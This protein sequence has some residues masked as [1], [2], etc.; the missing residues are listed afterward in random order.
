VTR[1]IL[2][3]VLLLSA[4]GSDDAP[5]QAEAPPEAPF[6]FVD[7]AA[8]AGVTAP[9]WCGGETKPHLLESGGTGLA[10]VDYDADGDLDLYLVNGWR[11]DGSRVVERGKNV[12]YRN[13]GDGSF[14]DATAEAGVGDEGW[15]CGVAVGD[16]DGDALPDLYVSNFG[17]DVLYRNRGDGSF[18][19]LA[20]APS[21]DGWSAGA[22]FFDA[23]GDGDEDLFV[24]GYV[25]ATLEE[26]LNAEPTLEWEG[27]MV[28]LGPFGLQGE[29][30]RYFENLGGGR[31]RDATEATGLTDEGLYYSFAVVALDVDADLDL[32]LYIANDSNPNYLYR[33]DGAGHFQETGLWSGAALDAAGNAQGGMG[34]AAG[35][36]DGD[37]DP[38]LVV[39]NF[40]RDASTL[41]ENLGDALFVDISAK[42]GVAEPSFKPLSWGAALADFDL[43]GDL[44]LF[45]ANG[46]IYPQ[47]D[48]VP[49][50][51]VG[52]A[53]ANLLLA[54]EG[55]RFSDTV[56]AAGPG[57]AALGS[58]RGV[59][60]GDI[61]NDGDLDLAV[62]NVDAPPTLLRNDTP[63]RGN[64]LLV[65]APGAR[66]VVIEAGGRRFVREGLVGASYLSA[67]D[68]RF[69]FGLGPATEVDSLR[70]IWPDGSE[71]VRS[72]LAPNQRVSVRR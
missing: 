18:E 30:N 42:A 48:E 24:A 63:H 40:G 2:V 57:L 10:F 59:A 23:D 16:A 36:A 52:Y 11:L 3:P 45:I 39:M 4:C 8:E 70:V 62:A 33:N 55:G 19:E 5:P 72:G 50:V 32:D 64:W 13:R 1:W 22:V 20:G 29:A 35:D 65:D 47:A 37:G 49:E 53:Q 67:S 38:E 9:T 71:T 61:D 21:I 41:Y 60:V 56:G 54:N 27:R 14:E 6:H 46:H 66:R 44:D 15:G 31:F 28:M 26:V 25:E 68:P 58:S 7:V 17:P 51:A 34:L 69:H 43:D 12:L